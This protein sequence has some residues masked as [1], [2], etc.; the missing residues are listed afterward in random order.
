MGLY[1]GPVSFVRYKL[2]DSDPEDI[3][4][5]VSEKLK[6][7]S[8]REIDPLS[9][10]EKSI[11]WV[12]V[13][14]MAATFFDDLHFAK[15]PYLVFSLRMDIRRIPAL[16][17]KAALLREEIKYKKAMGQ[18]RL[19]KKDK[20]MLRDEVWQSLIK[21]SLPLPS[22]YDVCWNT[23][24]GIVFFFSNSKKAAEEFVSFF[25]RSFDLKLFPLVPY[26]LA[27]VVL[28]KK[29]KNINIKDLAINFT[30]G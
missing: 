25:Y 12:S 19:L 18:E 30:D 22:V 24:T 13:E 8:F 15:E 21:K 28:K 4:E 1:S 16:T 7:F 23:S 29:N 27:G 2:S 6:E 9:L 10:S 5:F 26:D 3:K 17:M 11:G 20:D 14:N